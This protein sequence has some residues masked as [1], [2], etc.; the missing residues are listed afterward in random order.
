MGD[1]ILG[2]DAWAD[3]F[4]PGVLIENDDI[5]MTITTSPRINVLLQA[6]DQLGVDRPAGT[7]GDIGAIEI[8]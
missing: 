3:L 4:S 6:L 7:L 8:P 5:T 1:E 2:D